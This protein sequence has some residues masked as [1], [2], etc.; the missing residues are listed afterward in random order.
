VTGGEVRE[1][2]LRNQRLT[3]PPLETA[4]EVVRRLGAVQSQDYGGAKWGVAQR[5]RGLLDAGFDALFAAGAILR[6]HVMRPTWHFVVPDDIRWMLELTAPRV[7]AA[8]AYYYERLELDRATLRRSGQA[9]AGALGRG[10]QLTRTELAGVLQRAGIAAGSMRLAYMVMHAELD[11]I[12][13]SGARRGKQ[14][15]YALLDERASDARSLP[16]EEALAELACRY[17]SSHGPALLQDYAWWSGLTMADAQAGIDTA[18]PRL[19]REV[20]G[21]K[22]FWFAPGSAPQ[23]AAPTVHLL[24]NYDEYLVAHRDHEL[25]LDASLLPDGA[26]KESVLGGH[27]L[28]VDGWVVGGWR[29]TLDRDRVTLEVHP[30]VTLD[31]AAAEGLARAVDRYG[32]FLTLAAELTVR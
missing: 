21:G 4:V 19:V 26:S 13:C 16:R 1:R 27:I 8:N 17:F 2:R 23:E 31:G 6:T 32:T 12:I 28:V 15:T 10:G 29:R 18:R 20:V 22:V 30:L 5:C 7:H 9:I 24:P 25:T 11:A 14:F 3:G